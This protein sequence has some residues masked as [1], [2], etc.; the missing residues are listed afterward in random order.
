[1]TPA[2]AVR[3]SVAV[4]VVLAV[5]GCGRAAGGT[6]P[7][8]DPPPTYYLQLEL[9]DVWG[10]ATVLANGFPVYVSPGARLS[11][12]GPLPAPLQPAL[13]SGRNVVAVQIEPFVGR[14]GD[15]PVVGPVRA[16]GA[17]TR[18][19]GGRWPVGGAGVPAAAVDSAF[20]RWE[21]ELERRWP[22]WLAAED[23][24]FAA[25][26]GLLA[27]LADSVSA[28]PEAGAY[29]VGPALDSARAWARAHPVVV[30]TSFV[31]PGGSRPSDGGPA[32][33]GVFREAPALRGTAADSARLRDYAVHL[34]ALLDAADAEAVYDEIGPAISDSTGWYQVT[35]EGTRESDLADI[36]E[37]WTRFRTDFEPDDLGLRSWSGGRV[38][39]VY[40]DDGASRALGKR[41]LLLMGEDRLETWLR[42]YVG[43]VDG[44]LRVVRIT[45]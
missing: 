44:R 31:R 11:D 21:R 5:A 20:G 9:S 7:P 42:V 22:R 43:E 33:D 35:M 27:A 18:G 24:V 36:R 4:V 29:G 28:D 2:T 37:A 26:P 17:V 32:F 45:S 14:S 12:D 8:D 3:L 15:G 39:E 25:D 19:Y 6:A 34:G 10:Q 13:V 40:R 1:M 30:A 23:S 16:S 38:W 41:A